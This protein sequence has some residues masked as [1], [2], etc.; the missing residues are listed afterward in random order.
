[1]KK[2]LLLALLTPACAHAAP[3]I[4]SITGTF[5][6]NGVVVIN[7][8]GYGTKAQ[9]KPLIWA[10]FD[11]GIN[12]SA[13]GVNATWNRNQNVVWQSNGGF[14]N[15]GGAA[16]V[17]GIGVWTLGTSYASGWNAYDQKMYLF[18]RQRM[19]FLITDPSQ[20]WKAWRNWPASYD[21][22]PNMYDAYNVALLNVEKISGAAV[23]G[24][25]IN[26]NTTTWIQEERL[27]EA[28]SANGVKDATYVHRINGVQKA[29]KLTITRSASYPNLI[30]GN[31]VAHGVLANKGS[32][33][34]AWS[35]SNQEWWDDI[36]L[37]D[38][39]QRA[40]VCESAT[41]A[42]CRKFGFV[43]PSAWSNTQITGQVALPQ[44]DFLPGSTVYVHVFDTS[45]AGPSS[46]FQKF[47][48]GTVIGDP[49]PVPLAVQP[50]EGSYLGTTIATV[51][52]T[53]FGL[54]P[55]V[56]VGTIAATSVTRLNS[57]A[58]RFTIP[59]GVPGSSGLDLVIFNSD[60]QSGTIISTMSYTSPAPSNQAPYEV[61][62]GYDQAV[63][64]PTT[65]LLA[66][67]A[68]DDGLPASPGAL[69]YQW[70]K[71]SGTG[72]VTFTAG[73]SLE[74]EAS[75]SAAGVYVL[76]MTATDGTLSTDS[77]TVEVIVSP[78][79]VS[80]YPFKRQ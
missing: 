15:G 7:G 62:A 34:P 36:Y 52:G 19:N 74:T 49:P 17:A 16:G 42:N 14:G 80:R 25:Q 60:N 3:S 41:F 63:T 35:N 26:P 76:K 75:F 10:P 40:M 13:L 45:N 50:S 33:T 53:G 27:V 54:D 38:T 47:V 22:Y 24:S 57:T 43:I 61:Q 4:S 32:W 55:Q 30:V 78:A 77:N 67:S 70:A 79:P 66:S 71:V 28:S 18:R 8:S 23:Y 46:G 64:L 56:Y 11:S 2:L 51:T 1:M 31:Y 72:T 39:W 9:P 20:N 37:D 21:G 44:G 59:A 12:P 65:A 48:G 58:I 68:S 69:S 5:E 73:T 29:S 6:Q